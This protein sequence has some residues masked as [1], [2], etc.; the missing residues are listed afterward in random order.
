MENCEITA[1]QLRAALKETLA[2]SGATHWIKAK[3]RTDFIQQILKDGDVKSITEVNGFRERIVLSCIFNFLQARNLFNTLSVYTS[4][5][6][7]HRGN[8]LDE[9]DLVQILKR[10]LLDQEIPSI[11]EMIVK[12]CFLI[13]EGSQRDQ[14]VQTANTGPSAKE[15]LAEQ[16]QQ[17]SLTTATPESAE[18]FEQHL[19]IYHRELEARKDHEIELQM[20]TFRE[21]E[22]Q[23]YRLQDSEKLRSSLAALHSELELDYQRRLQ[24]YVERESES[25]YR[26]KEE[27]KRFKKLLHE[28]R[29]SLE[30]QLE[31]LKFKESGMARK[32]E[33]ENQGFRLLEIR[34]K[35]LESK[36]ELKA[37]EL[38]AK[39]KEM[40]LKAVN[41]KANL[42]QE[43]LTEL[44]A[45]RSRIQSEK[46]QFYDEK[47]SLFEEKLKLQN[48]MLEMEI[49]QKSLM[50]NQLKV[51]QLE[52]ANQSLFKEL[53]ITKLRIQAEEETIL[54]V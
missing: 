28:E 36:L 25:A 31:E 17:L 45:E 50:E 29:Q 30:K 22:L 13:A 10:N 18:F 37:R 49:A 38:D 2:K 16:I 33:L 54:E 5:A 40:D 21:Q 4:E 23:K 15:R 48:S 47:K 6:Q 3:L 39:E 26:L 1:K 41:F 14:E 42:R 24:F 12:S 19:S 51:K 43:L 32:S 44:A 35:E 52:Q 46:V 34:L 11:L 53:E 7:L 27:E 9:N 8:I 20:K